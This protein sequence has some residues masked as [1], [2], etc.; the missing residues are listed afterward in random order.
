[1]SGPNGLDGQEVGESA[2]L[3]DALEVSM[4]REA[5]DC[6]DAFLPFTA[7]GLGDRRRFRVRY[8]SRDFFDDRQAKVARL[9]LFRVI[10]VLASRPLDVPSR[11]VR[12]GR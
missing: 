2:F 7:Y 8:A 12:V 10:F 4:E 3:H 9:S 6:R 1:M 5:N 11:F